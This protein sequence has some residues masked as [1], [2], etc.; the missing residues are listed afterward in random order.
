LTYTFLAIGWAITAYLAYKVATTKRDITIWNPYDILGLDESA[1]EKQIKK[2]YKKLSI[3]FHP[4]KVK[5]AVNQTIEDVQEQFVGLTK[6]YKALTDDEVRQNYIDYGHPDGKQDMSV[7]IAL[8]TWMVEGGQ[9]LWVLAS[10]CLALLV[11]LPVLVGRWWYR[12][13]S[14]TKEGLLNAT[15]ERYFRGVE[16]DLTSDEL[17]T[18]LCRA[19]EFDMLP[20]PHDQ[21]DALA[22]VVREANMEVPAGPSRTVE[23]LVR[24]HLARIQLKTLPLIVAQ[25]VVLES[26]MEMHK[27]LLNNILSYGY[28]RTALKL[29]ELGP[30]LAQ[31]VLPQS[32][33]L[34]QLP[35]I[36]QTNAIKDL[37]LF[38][39]LQME[40]SKRKSLLGLPDK[41]YS[42]VM[43]VAKALPNIEVP[44][45]FFKVAGDKEITPNAIVQMVFKIR[46]SGGPP[47][48][49]SDLEEIDQDEGNVEAILN[50]D[51]EAA[52]T[53]VEDTLSWSPY[54]PIPQKNSFWVFMADIKQ[55]RVIVGP[56]IAEDIGEKV[57]TF[58]LQFQAPPNAGLYTFQGHIKSSTYLGMDKTAHL[59]LNV[60]PDN[61]EKQEDEISE[62]DEDSLA[63]QMAAMKG[64]PVKKIKT[65][66]RHEYESSS[67]EDLISSDDD[68]DSD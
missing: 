5:L 63:G 22:A 13:A 24:A 19:A 6:A 65:D 23:I 12:S 61:T 39:F 38:E 3:K 60:V 25:Q 41:Q 33:C 34:L 7:G 40:N 43:K 54:L 53:A 45:V 32:S 66:Y 44:K 49:E 48:K 35:H 52:A 20:L 27:G 58:K 57:R 31:A 67:E 2:H 18:L 50:A 4:D 59:Q 42:E 8:P 56:L 10:Y 55:D 62:P 36:T 30:C 15:A 28:L 46:R 16:D 26:I 14:T 37:E 64:A 1:T 21:V 29:M 47:L 51:R 17:I 11:G 9:S 68:S